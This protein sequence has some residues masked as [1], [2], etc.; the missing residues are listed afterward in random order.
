MWVYRGIQEYSW[1]ICCMSGKKESENLGNLTLCKAFSLFMLQLREK[2]ANGYCAL[3]F[4]LLGI[5]GFSGDAENGMHLG[6]CTIKFAI[7]QLPN[8]SAFYLHFSLITLSECVMNIKLMRRQR[9]LP[10]LTII[11]NGTLINALKWISFCGMLALAIQTSVLLK[12]HFNVCPFCCTNWLKNGLGALEIKCN[13]NSCL[14]HLIT[15][16]ATG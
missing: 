2:S 15:L 8:V 4:D 12:L 5:Q 9:D 11:E 10:L 16:S 6:I 13:V 3:D 7:W 14:P 1:E